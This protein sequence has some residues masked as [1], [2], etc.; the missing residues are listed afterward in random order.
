MM[1]YLYLRRRTDSPA[2]DRV[3]RANIEFLLLLALMSSGTSRSSRVSFDYFSRGRVVNDKD[4]IT[5][6]S[7][8]GLCEISPKKK[9]WKCNESWL[10]RLVFV[11]APGAS[12]EPSPMSLRNIR[13]GDD[14]NTYYLWRYTGRLSFYWAIWTVHKKF[15][16]AGCASDFSL[17]RW[18]KT[19]L[20][21]QH[22]TRYGKNTIKWLWEET[23]SRVKLFF[24]P[25]RFHPAGE[26]F[27]NN[28]TKASHGN[29]LSLAQWNLS[30]VCG[31]NTAAQLWQTISIR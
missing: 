16:S 3:Y 15:V 21:R 12:S 4:M 26:C 28:V 23:H 25:K 5:E 24:S 9:G 27:V 18:W 13:V 11:N 6:Q 1:V 30:S 8:F 20:P 29:K 7:A 14:G 2:T 17:S 19:L 31:Y 10:I 22:E